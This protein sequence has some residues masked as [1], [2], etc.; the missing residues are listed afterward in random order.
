MRI[1]VCLICLIIGSILFGCVTVKKDSAVH[2]Q[3][4]FRSVEG[5]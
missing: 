2:F 5:K 3:K 1:L 4:Q